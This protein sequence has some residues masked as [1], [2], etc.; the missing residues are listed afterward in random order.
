[1]CSSDLRRDKREQIRITAP[2][3]VPLAEAATAE[4]RANAFNAIPGA[5]VQYRVAG[6]PWLEMTKTENETDPVFQKLFDEEKQL[7]DKVPWRKLASPMVCPHLWKA[8]LGTVAGTG[9][10]LIEVK[11]TNPNGQVLEGQRTIRVD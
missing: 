2:E 10:L 11:V 8:P 1:M 3:S 7:G 9:N 6:G 5:L 4:F